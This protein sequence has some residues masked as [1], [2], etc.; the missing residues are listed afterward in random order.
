M[1]QCAPT[2]EDQAALQA[3]RSSGR[4]ISELG[5]AERIMIELMD[6][7]NVEGRLR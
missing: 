4:P 5:D 2:S 6:V 1:Q 3:Y 7:P